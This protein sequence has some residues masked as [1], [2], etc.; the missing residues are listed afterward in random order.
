MNAATRMASQIGCTPKLEHPPPPKLLVAVVGSVGGGGVAQ[1]VVPQSE[2]PPSPP[3]GGGGA[4][5]LPSAWR[6]SAASCAR[7]ESM[8]AGLVVA[9]ASSS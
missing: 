9:S 7:A 2:L 8:A 4:V 3:G 5:S 6:I 1:A